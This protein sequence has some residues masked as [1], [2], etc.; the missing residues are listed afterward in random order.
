MKK[1]LMM[2]LVA[3]IGGGLL[4]F[5]PMMAWIADVNHRGTMTG[6]AEQFSAL[7]DAEREA[8][9]AKAD[10]YN[11]RLVNKEVHLTDEVTDQEYN[12]LL[13]I[14]GTSTMGSV[15]VPSIGA[16]LPIY[17]GISDDTLHLGAGH[18]YGTSLPV[19]G[20]GTHAAL[21]AHSGIVDA[22]MF[23]HLEDVALGDNFT[24]D[25]AGRQMTYQ[26][27]DI[28]VVIPEDINT[29]TIDPSLDQVT[30][31]TCTPTGVNTHRL[32]VT[33]SRVPDLAVTGAPT[34][35]MSF[36]EFPGFPWW[37]VIWAAI[38]AAGAIV[39]KLASPK[40]AAAETA[41][42]ETEDIP[43]QPITTESI[44]TKP[45][46]TQPI[47]TRASTRKD[48]MHGQRITLGGTDSCL[49]AT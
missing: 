45:I 25:V 12:A 20:V 14:P 33:G 21:S 3:A 16:Y 28:R 27:D 44:P 26:V 43:T 23:T 24:V 15:S 46:R 9:L 6:Y 22:D 48:R 35:T 38:I 31:I 4:Q 36:W 37:A 11:T 8:I 34:K 13:T 7:N 30:L 29:I 17:H 49:S 5:A 19:G 2:M 1:I 32:L 47:P 42:A 18:L 40:P 10:A 39:G 41:A